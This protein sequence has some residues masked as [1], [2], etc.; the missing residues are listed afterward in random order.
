MCSF[1]R[2]R[3][4]LYC[5]SCGEIDDSSCQMF[6]GCGPVNKG[7][8]TFHSQVMAADANEGPRFAR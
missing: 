7:V 8:T 6:W 5:N 1:V 2:C 3:A 4:V